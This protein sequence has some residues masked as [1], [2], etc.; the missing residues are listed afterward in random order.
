MYFDTCEAD[1]KKQQQQKYFHRRYVRKISPRLG[2]VMHLYICFYLNYQFRYQIRNKWDVPEG[3]FAK[4]QGQIYYSAR[5][6]G[7][8][9]RN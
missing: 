2:R 5:L 6:I 7:Q 1:E 9:N 3:T 4:V 8:Q